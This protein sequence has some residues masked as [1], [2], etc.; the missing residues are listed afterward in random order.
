MD[1][2][3]TISKIVLVDNKEKYGENLENIRKSITQKDKI[4]CTRF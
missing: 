4:F 1:L 3:F 2:P